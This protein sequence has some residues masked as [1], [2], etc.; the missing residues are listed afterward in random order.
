[1]I[2]FNKLTLIVLLFFS[3]TCL[4]SQ[5]KIN[6]KLS[7]EEIES[8]IDEHHNDKKQIW[9]FINL[10]IK[11]AK[12]EK[13]SEA[14]IYAYRYATNYS[15]YPENIRYSDTALAI[16]QKSNDKI[17]L[18]NAYINRGGIFMD[19]SFYQK[20]IDDILIANK[21]ANELGD[22]FL[23][24]RTIYLLAQNKIYLGLYEDANKEL[25]QCINFFKSN[26]SNSSFEKD[27]EIY[28]IYSLMSYID[29]NTKIGK[30]EENK[31]LVQEGKSYLNTNNLKQ[32]LPYFHSYEGTDAYYLGNYKKAEEKL[33]QALKLYDDQWS[34]L[35]EIYYLGQIY[36]NT[37]RK[38]LAIKYLEEIDNEYN[39]T[40]KLDPQFRAAYE[41]LIKHYDSI[42]NTSKQLE[43][44]NKLMTLDKS[45][46]KHY[47]YL[48]PKINKE[49]D[50]K[51]LLVEKYKIEKS[52]KKQRL[53]LIST[54]ILSS[55]IVL[56]ISFRYFKL[57]K[58]YKE[59]FN[60]ILEESNEKEIV[61]E[62]ESES[63][64][65]AEI[66]ENSTKENDNILLE[67]FPTNPH[68]DINYY[69]KIPGMKPAFVKNI[70]DQLEIFERDEKFLD[71]Q[72]TQRLL[73]EKLGTNS[74]YLSRIINTYKDKKFTNYINDLRLEF[75]IEL[76]K[77]DYNF[78]NMDVKELSIIAGF[79]SSE[80]YSDNFQR[81]Y[82]I[83]PSYFIKMMREK[84]LE[85]NKIV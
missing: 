56:L 4:F 2:Y 25:K 72:I 20:A 62:L 70:L 7:Y 41:I 39:K 6:I 78:L 67:L 42:G 40:N 68:H 26:L 28:Y 46:E 27:Y 29:S 75:T 11:K 54:I 44:I 21:L 77:T 33:L 23:R 83:K 32:L 69:S 61:E 81:K 18:T 35:T 51:K 53:I 12:Q 15:H 22:E 49:Y 82:K 30:H 65:E 47:R 66:E 85:E 64:L 13:N 52:L 16:G 10:Y 8:K 14:L 79:S 50:T 5:Q 1:M 36:W 38:N 19:E 57:Q 55:L 59:R 9:N 74:T 71:P 48:Y 24:Y 63:I 58:N 3:F 34:H 17:L 31:I 76:L 60:Q 84:Y 37:G 45:F 80:N 43:Y 73:S